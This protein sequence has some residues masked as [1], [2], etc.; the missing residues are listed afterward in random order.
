MDLC[1]QA[2]DIEQR[3]ESGL[4]PWTMSGDELSGSANIS[5]L[6]VIQRFVANDLNRVKELY[7]AIAEVRISSSNAFIEI[8]TAATADTGS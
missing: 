3:F 2:N 7:G 1:K 6:G 4:T 8:S 5:V